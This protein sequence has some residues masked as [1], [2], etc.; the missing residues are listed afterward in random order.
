VTKHALG[1]YSTAPPAGGFRWADVQEDVDALPRRDVCETVDDTVGGTA[2]VES[3]VVQHDRE[4]APERVIA[5]CLLDDGRRAWATSEDAPT[6]AEMVSGAE[7]IGRAIKVDA[8]GT[9]LL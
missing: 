2:T 3:W 6:L 7:Q 9:L 8:T 4:G 1:L 5:S